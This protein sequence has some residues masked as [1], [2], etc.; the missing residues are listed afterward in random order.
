VYN[1]AAVYDIAAVYNKAAVYDI[2][3]VYEIAAVYTK[4]EILWLALVVQN[5]FPLARNI[6]FVNLQVFQ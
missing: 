1:K 6:I 5:G 3:A 2:A 4:F